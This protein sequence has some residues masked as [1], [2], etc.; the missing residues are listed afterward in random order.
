M[1]DN[2]YN[3]PE[4][5]SGIPRRDLLKGLAGI[6]L[7]GLFGA[8]AWSKQT[9]DKKIQE[10]ILKELNIEAAVPPLPDLSGD[11]VRI[12]IIGFGIRGKQLMRALGFATPDWKKEMQKAAA[13]NP[14]DKRWETFATQDNLNLRVTGVCDVFDVRAEEAIAAGTV[15][16][17]DPPKR[18]RTYEEMLASPDIDAVVIATPDHWHAPMATAAALAGKHVYVEKCMTHKFGE[19]YALRQAVQDSGIIFQVG[20]QHRQTQSFLTAMDVIKKNVLGHVSLIQTNTNR[21]DDNGA[22]QYP[23]HDQASPQTIDWQQFLGNAP[24]I[25]FNAEHFFRWR[26]WWP[27]GTGLAG[28]LLTHD[29]DRINCLLQMGIPD[30]VISSGG[31]YTHRDG[32]EVPDVWQVV[33]EFPDYTTGTS[34]EAG[35][36]KG[37]TFMYSATLGNQYNRGTLLM[38]HD[39]TMELGNTLFVYPD[40]RS[41]RYKDMLGNDLVKPDV[42]LYAYNPS[43]K[44]GDGITSATAAY[45]ANKGLLYTYRDG[46][47]VDSTHLHMREWLAAIRQNKPDLVSCGINEGFQEAISALMACASY[48]LGRRIEWDRETER[49]KNVTEEELGE[50][51]MA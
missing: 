43:S 2:G 14:N 24:Q 25:P 19:T 21:N 38:G 8:G 48:K 3:K 20:H 4:G 49:V 36:E 28:D 26:K 16:G 13:Q 41:T 46:K 15:D 45:F 11:P 40:A 37:L 7:L 42:P 17:Q 5:N 30:S 9:Y 39:A 6:P 50:V 1:A 32:R 12:G 51:G 31:I 44:G 18:F 47:R 29:Y 23:I 27:Y 34:Q 35:K 22:W 33:M 10:Q